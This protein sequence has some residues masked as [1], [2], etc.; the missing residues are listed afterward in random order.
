MEIPIWFNEPE[1]YALVVT[2]W[3]YLACWVIVS[4]IH[5][6]GLKLEIKKKIIGFKHWYI[7]K[8]EAKLY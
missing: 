3:F 1:Y 7:K 2:I 6:K 4:L 8:K 5:T